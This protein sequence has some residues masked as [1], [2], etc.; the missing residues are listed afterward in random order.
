M[1]KNLG[2]KLSI[3]ILVTTL[4]IL[5]TLA[6]YIGADLAGKGGSHT[7]NARQL[8]AD[9][10]REDGL[11]MQLVILDAT[12]FDGFVVYEGKDDDLA[13]YFYENL[14]QP[15]LKS[16]DRGDL[17]DEIYKE[18]MYAATTELSAKAEDEFAKADEYYAKQG[19]LS[20]ITL[21]AA[22]GLSFA[23]YASLLDEEN[24]LRS[25]FASIAALALG[26]ILI[27]FLRV[28]IF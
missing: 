19:S 21:F 2:S 3:G 7:A 23:G 14:S 11:A 24:R 13:G 5:A 26:L 16:I 22:L 8:L 20:V 15:L 17:F 1:I 27:Q 9:A 4:S 12:T 28:F 10:N 25:I 18:E 6:N